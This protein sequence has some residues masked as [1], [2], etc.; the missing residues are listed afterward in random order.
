MMFISKNKFL[1]FLALTT[2][3]A[4]N[5]AVQACSLSADLG[6]HSESDYDVRKLQQFRVAADTKI[7]CELT[8]T[9]GGLT[10]MKIQHEDPYMMGQYSETKSNSDCNMVLTHR[11]ASHKQTG[12]LEVYIEAD[13]PQ[14]LY[15]DCY[16]DQEA[17]Q[18]PAPTQ[19][20][21]TPSP[22][23]TTNGVRGG[24]SGNANSN[25]N[26]SPQSNSPARA[27]P[28]GNCFSE[29]ALVQVASKGDIAMKDLQLGDRV[30]T[31]SGTYQPVYSFGH[32]QTDHKA[33]FLQIHTSIDSSSSKPLEMTG[34]HLIFLAN[35]ETVPAKNLQ[36]ISHWWL[37]PHR[38][39]CMN[40]LWAND[41][42]NM[43]CHGKNEDGILHYLIAGQE[44]ARAVNQYKALVQVFVLGIP[45]FLFFGLLNLLEYVCLGPALAPL[46]MLVGFLAT[47][48]VWLQNDGNDSRDTKKKVV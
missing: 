28:A 38:M 22:T 40:V 34:N 4:T 46:V 21:K 19:A 10:T 15:L 42:K 36:T 30:L 45:L 2:T 6:S 17:I 16:C 35:G 26:V 13:A 5:T 41:S 25:S 32:Y 11:T 24:G 29:S 7:T 9:S 47:V 27:A 43:L 8:C 44:M 12:F 20:P 37:A 48:G 14:D 31:A 3:T 39:M 1:A 33:T 18:T 23:I